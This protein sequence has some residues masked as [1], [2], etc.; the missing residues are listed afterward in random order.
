MKHANTEIPKKQ[1]TVIP[2]TPEAI[3]LLVATPWVKCHGRHPGI[4]ARTPRNNLP[5]RQRPN[6]HEVVLT[7]G[8]HILSVRGPADTGKPAVVGRI[9]IGEPV[10]SQLRGFV[11]KPL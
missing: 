1:L 7:A 5:L 3:R 4:V 6:R 10:Q 11:Y 8:E 2:N 9:Y